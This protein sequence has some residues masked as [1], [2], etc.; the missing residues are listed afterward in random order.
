ML[1]EGA[2]SEGLVIVTRVSLAE[3][4][5]EDPIP[6]Y[7]FRIPVLGLTHEEVARKYRGFDGAFWHGPWG[8]RDWESEYGFLPET[9]IGD[10]GQYEQIKEILARDFGPDA[11][12]IC[13][14]GTEALSGLPAGF[15]FV[16]YDF[17]Y[18]GSARGYY[19]VLYNEVIYGL[20]RA[21][22][23]FGD[24]LNENLLLSS[25]AEAERLDAVRSRLLEE[26]ADLETSSDEWY[27]IGVWLYAGGDGALR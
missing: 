1:E 5:R 9:G 11:D 13:F 7:E 19:S 2:R 21:M 27:A 15:A 23:E 26:G 22:R 20:I 14:G 3:A 16:G 4:H 18:Y 6:G 17:G 24:F 25:V 10:L 8:G 12:L